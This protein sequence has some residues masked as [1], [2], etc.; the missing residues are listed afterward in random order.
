MAD[1]TINNVTSVLTA[2]QFNAFAYQ[3]S[4]SGPSQKWS[5][6]NLP[7]GLACDPDTGLI[8]GVPTEGGVYELILQTEQPGGGV[9]R[10]NVP[11]AVESLGVERVEAV[12]LTVDV[13]RGGVSGVLPVVGKR[14]DDLFFLIRFQRGGVPAVVAVSELLVAVKLHEA[15]MIVVQSSGWEKVVLGDADAYVCR[16]SLAN[17]AIDFALADTPFGDGVPA[18]CEISWVETVSSEWGIGKTTLRHSAETIALRIE[19]RLPGRA[20]WLLN[21]TGV[22]QSP[23]TGQWAANAAFYEDEASARQ[24]YLEWQKVIW[25][26]RNS[27]VH[28]FLGF[29]AYN[30]DWYASESEARAAEAAVLDI[31]WL[32]ANSG[33]H[34]SPHTGRWAFAH[35]WYADEEQAREAG[36]A[37]WLAHNVGVNHCPLRFDYYLT[38]AYNQNWKA[39]EEAARTHAAADWIAGNTGVNQCPFTGQWAFNATFYGSQAEATQAEAFF[40]D[41]DWLSSNAGIHQS[42]H[43]GR[44]AFNA[45]FYASQAAANAAASPVNFTNRANNQF[46]NLANWA[47][48]DV[49]VAAVRLPTGVDAVVLTA[50]CAVDMDIWVQPA[51]IALGAFSLT[52][53]STKGANLTCPVSG[54]GIITLN[55]VKFNR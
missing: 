12:E 36:A 9:A 31:A 49:N 33:L 4:A 55:G 38:W 26:A 40:F 2:V 45:T 20:E 46:S 7:P 19:Q 54:T 3:P 48:G 32:A 18:L 53:T 50:N 14:G 47:T 44:W 42:P 5:A 22:N 29:W 13:K 52:L 43:T 16:I 15:E 39:D 25:V 24:A 41:I 51:S 35:D 28:E 6:V 34:Q 17:E 21:N 27:G 8:S 37:D 10:L 23:Y 11:M 30:H 1:F